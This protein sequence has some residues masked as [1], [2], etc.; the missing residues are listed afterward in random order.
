MRH[1]VAWLA[2]IVALPVGAQS[3]AACDRGG[4]LSAAGIGPL[5]IGM[6]IDSLGSTCRVISKRFVAEYSATLYEVRVGADTA[7]VWEHNGTVGLITIDSPVHRT[8]D[9]LGV[10][11]ATAQVLHLADV[12]GSAGD[13]DYVLYTRSGL[14]CGLTFHL[15]PETSQMMSGAKGDALRLLQMRGSGVVSSVSIRGECPRGKTQ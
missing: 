15:D 4:A 11:S 5:R 3:T 12:T 10:G 13:G 8:R 7:G 14:H 1:A 9:S 2:L 6:R